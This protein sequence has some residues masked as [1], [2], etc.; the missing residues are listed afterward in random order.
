MCR[1]VVEDSRFHNG[2]NSHSFCRGTGVGLAKL[3]VLRS[4]VCFRVN[5]SPFEVT[6]ESDVMGSS[7]L[8]LCLVTCSERRRTLL[9]RLPKLHNC[10]TII[11]RNTSHKCG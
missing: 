6:S 4:T 8:L 3:V 5:N 2:F 9:L 1:N 7:V 10:W 11:K